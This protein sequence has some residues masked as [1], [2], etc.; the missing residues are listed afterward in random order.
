M[1]NKRSDGLYQ[2]NVVVGRKA[3]GS[4]IRK[5]VYGKT[6]KE[7]DLKISEITQQVHQGM[8]V[9]DNKATFGEMAEIWLTRYNPTANK[10][11]IYRQEGVINKHLMPSLKYMKLKDLKAYHL[12]SIINEMAKDGISTSTMKKAR[13]QQWLGTKKP[14][15]KVW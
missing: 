11:W 8:Y 10:K 6:K 12:Q 7:L 1:A 3:D 14:L 13:K 9:S 5:T 2:K 4:Y 15:C